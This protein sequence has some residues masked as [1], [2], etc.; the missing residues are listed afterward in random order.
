M[1]AAA[2]PA[3]LLDAACM[4][5]QAAGRFP[6]H[7]ARGKLRADPAY[8]AILEYGLLLGR[9]RLL[10]LGCG[11][12]LLPSWLRAAEHCYS[13]GLWP[14]DWPAAPTGLSIRGIERMA[15][16]VNWARRALG[17]QAEITHG[18]IRVA[19]FGAADAVVILDVLHYLPAEAHRQI[20]LRV[21]GALPD[22]GLLLLRVGDAAAGLRF[23][24]SRWFDTAVMLARGHPAA[25]LHCRSVVQWRVLLAGCGFDSQALSMPQ[26]TAFANTLLIARA[27]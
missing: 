2:P 24:F 14:S 20:L 3:A 12:G 13:A 7:F 11:Q 10:D 1:S 22:A 15:R 23:R 18:D 17:T 27:R 8:H 25:R 6:Y 5:Y 9:R 4:P 21:R 26:G 16:E 19:D